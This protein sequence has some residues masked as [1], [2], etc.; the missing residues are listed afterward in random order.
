MMRFK[1]E[2]EKFYGK[3]RKTNAGSL[4]VTVP[5]QVCKFAGYKEGD[6]LVFMCKKKEDQNEK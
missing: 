4:E 3:L 2:Y 6:E 1:M 5:A